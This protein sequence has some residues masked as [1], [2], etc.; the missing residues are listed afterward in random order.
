M[1]ENCKNCKHVYYVYGCEFGCKYYDR[2]ECSERNL[3]CFESKVPSD[4]QSIQTL[5]ADETEN[6]AIKEINRLKKEVDYWKEACNKI[7]E[8]H[9]KEEAQLR[10][11]N[12]KLKQALENDF[13]YRTTQ[14]G[15]MNVLDLVRQQAVK[16]FAE[17]L[18]EK[19][20]N[21]YQVGM[22]ILEETEIDNLLKEYKV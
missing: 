17:K 22:K 2:G 16:E 11:E 7:Q 18:K 3:N 1:V 8:K 10:A 14:G 6:D 19:C 20:F 4:L 9:E 15:K 21:G 12:N 5:L 13:T